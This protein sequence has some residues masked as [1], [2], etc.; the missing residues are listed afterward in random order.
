[1]TKTV[2]FDTC[3][4]CLKVLQHTNRMKNRKAQRL[5]LQTIFKTPKYKLAGLVT[6]NIIAIQFQYSTLDILQYC[7]CMHKIKVTC[8]LVA[9]YTVLVRRVDTLT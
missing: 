8:Y 2:L 1:M 7:Q 6:E 4:Q 3:G 5:Q 9:Y